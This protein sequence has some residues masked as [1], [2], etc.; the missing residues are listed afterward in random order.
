MMS[1]KLKQAEQLIKEY[2][3]ESTEGSSN[4]GFM[5]DSEHI[6]VQ[7]HRI[8]NLGKDPNYHVSI[9]PSIIYRRG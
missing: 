5:V 4:K 9:I 2:L 3:E 6:Y 1:D 8:D 7:I